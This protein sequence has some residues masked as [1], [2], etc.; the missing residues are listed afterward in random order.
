MRHSSLS[1]R[2]TVV[3]ELIE[4]RKD[5]KEYLELNSRI[6]YAQ[7]EIDKVSKKGLTSNLNKKTLTLLED[8]SL[9]SKKPI[10]RFLE[11]SLF[12]IK[13]LKILF[14]NVVEIF[15]SSNPNEEG[16]TRLL[17]Q[18]KT[19]EVDINQLITSI[20]EEDHGPIRDLAQKNMID[21]SL[22]LFIVSMIIQPYIEE[23]ANR[24]SSSF[25][26][27]WW[28]TICPICG[29]KPSTARVRK[30]R[31]FLVCNFCGAEYLSDFFICVNCGNRDPYTLKYMKFKEEEGFQIDYC[32]KCKHYLKIINEEALKEPIPRLMEDI[33][34]L[35]LDLKAKQAGLVRT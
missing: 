32:T 2:L 35:D 13:I 30:R 11:I 22:L 28:K 18:L 19:D 31:R 23:I 24:A 17:N 34:S 29:R 15:A 20:L 21:S 33:L 27:R 7:L 10:I 5:L 14:K 6:L 9:K 3:N 8:K 12:D 1:E 4:R 16:L 26:E 25:Y